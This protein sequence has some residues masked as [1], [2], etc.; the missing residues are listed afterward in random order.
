MLTF[1]DEQLREKLKSEPDTTP[2]TFT[3]TRFPTW[4]K[5]CET[6]RKNFKFIHFL[7]PEPTSTVLSTTFSPGS[8]RK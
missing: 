7:F 6:S 8:C 1:S 5:V 3:F 2:L 4:S